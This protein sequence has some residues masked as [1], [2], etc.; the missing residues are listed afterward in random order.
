MTPELRL[1]RRDHSGQIVE[2]ELDIPQRQDFLFHR[3]IADHLLTGEALWRPWK[4][5]FGWLQCLKLQRGRSKRRD[6]GGA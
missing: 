6:R 5:R 2:Q 4:N 1:Y 3:N